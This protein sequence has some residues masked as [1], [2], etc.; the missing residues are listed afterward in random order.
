MTCKYPIACCT[1]VERLSSG[2]SRERRKQWSGRSCLIPSHPPTHRLP[3]SPAGDTSNL[4]PP[5]GTCVTSKH[6]MSLFP[7]SARSAEYLFGFQGRRFSCASCC[8]DFMPS[9]HTTE[10]QCDRSTLRG[11]CEVVDT[12]IAACSYRSWRARHA[13]ACIKLTKSRRIRGVFADIEIFFH[14]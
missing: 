13:F 4:L 11:N 8:T 2:A 7:V 3:P 9:I 1:L 14:T 5:A 12:Q 6:D 10:K